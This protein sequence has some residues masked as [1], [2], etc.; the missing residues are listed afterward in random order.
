MSF[1][2]S[3]N[4]G[5][6]SASVFYTG[7]SSGSQPAGIFGDYTLTGLSNGNYTITP[8]LVGYRFFPPSQNVT[9]SGSNVT[10]VNFSAS[11]TV[12]IFR[13]IPLYGPE[14]FTDPVLT[15]NPDGVTDTPCRLFRISADNSA[16]IQT[17]FV[18][19]YNIGTPI[20]GVTPPQIV[21]RIPTGQTVYQEFHTGNYPGI[22]FS[23]LSLAAT[24]TGGLT[25]NAGPST[26]LVVS[27]TFSGD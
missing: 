24:T 13:I 14:T 18:K 4:A 7:T 27:A 3:G 22:F 15:N 5:A 26:N 23:A 6:G 8:S 25:G 2:I 20:V 21:L 16:G 9:I 17:L 11:N 12:N 1:S 19:A 10:G